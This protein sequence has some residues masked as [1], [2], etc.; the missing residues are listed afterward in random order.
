[1]LLTPFCQ[2]CW[3][4]RSCAAPIDLSIL[5]RRCAERRSRRPPLRWRSNW[6]VTTRTIY[7]D[8][9]TLQA[10]R[11]PIE[12]EPGLGYFAAQRLRSAAADVHDGGSR[13]HHYRSQ[14]RSSHS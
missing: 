1:M 10:R 12:G 14:P 11:I 2:W 6:G 3:E 7:R 8:I 13:G 4:G 9:A 5:S